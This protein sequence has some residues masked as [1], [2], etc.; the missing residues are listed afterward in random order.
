LGEWVL[1]QACHAA[2]HWPNLFIAVNLSPTQLRS[3]DFV[4]RVLAI[5][6]ESG[7][8]PHRIELEVTESVLLNDDDHMRETLRKLRAVGLRIA[9]DDFGTGYSSLSYLRRFEVDKIKIDRSFVQQLG[10]T[11]E[12]A[13]IVT[14]VV[15][16]GHAMGLAVTAEGVE[17]PEQSNFLSAVGCNTLQGYLFS[18]A[19]PK[20]EIAPLLA[21]R[22]GMRGAA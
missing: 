10:N 15:T 21:G 14:A 22:H 7:T 11:A 5:L 13:A 12:S 20:E 6:K 1:R 4:E 2:G 9:L 3:H 8:D 17:T 16:L 19:V 18:R